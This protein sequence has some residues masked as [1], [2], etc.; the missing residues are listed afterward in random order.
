MRKILQNPF[1]VPFIAV[2]VMALVLL[3][4]QRYERAVLSYFLRGI[5]PAPH[6]LQPGA[7]EDGVVWHVR[8]ISNKMLERELATPGIVALGDD[9]SG[10]FQASPHAPIDFAVIARNM[11][12]IGGESAAIGAVLAWD[13]PDEI[14]LTALERALE[15]FDT[16]VTTVPLARGATAEAIPSTFRRASLPLADVKG[17]ANALPMVNRKAISDVFLGDSNALAGFT[18]L[19]TNADASEP[20]L[21]A[22]WDDR[23]VFSFPFLVAMKQAGMGI[24]GLEI[25]LGSHIRLGTRGWMIPID[26]AGRMRV[27]VPQAHGWRETSAEGLLSATTDDWAG[28]SQPKMWIVRDDRGGRDAIFRHH[29]TQ[30]VPLVKT[31]ASGAALTDPKELRGV[32]DV[33]GWGLLGAVVVLLGALCRFG[34]LAIQIGLVFTLAG[35]IGLQWLALSLASLWMPAMPAILAINV[36]WIVALPIILSRRNKRRKNERIGSSESAMVTS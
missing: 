24:E 12:R 1:F 15:L 2:A 31:L 4:G 14:G 28:D 18:F 5:V 25:H 35:M 34:G 20:F 6:F 29:S 16:V 13:T 36:V 7:G 33:L 11:S 8:S 22:R 30:L 23:V 21:M 26:E 19:E 9:S 17:D 3:Q 10:V 27:V 32:P